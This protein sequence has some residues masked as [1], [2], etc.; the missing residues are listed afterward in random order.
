MTRVSHALDRIEVSFDDPNLVANAGLLLTSTL[1]DRLDLEA[2]IDSTVKLRGRVGGARP[3]RKVLTLTHAMIAG[4]THIDHAD[5]LRAGSTSAVLG[6]RVMAP[7]TIGTFLRAFTFGHVRQLEAVNGHALERA[8][9]TGIRPA[10]GLVIDIDSTICEVDGTH[11]Q[12]AGY[13]YTHKLGYRSRR[14][15]DPVLVD[16]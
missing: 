1:S 8:W 2:L 16:R 15:A 12:G 4:A 9:V 14:C 13:G 6:H 3:G 10:D 5:V 11:K 7:S